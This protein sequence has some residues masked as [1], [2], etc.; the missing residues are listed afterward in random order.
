MKKAARLLLIV[1]LFFQGSLDVSAQEETKRDRIL[2]KFSLSPQVGL[3]H[4]WGDFNDEGLG[5]FFDQNDLGLSLLLNYKLNKFISISTGGLYG[6]LSGTRDNVNSTGAVNEPKD[7]GFGI[8]F[9]TDLFEFT[10]PRVELNVTRLIFKDKSKIFNKISIGV[11]GSHGIVYSNSKIYSQQ[12][13]GVNL[14]YGKHRGRSGNTVEAVT[15]YGLGLSYIINDRFDIGIESTI[16]NVWNDRL[17]AWET[18]GTAND[19]YSY[20]A[21]GVKYHLKKRNDVVKILGIDQPNTLAKGAKVEEEKEEV[22]EV[23]EEKKEEV[24]EVVEEKKDEV[25]P[26]IEEKKEEVAEVVEEKKKEVVS[27]KEGKTVSAGDKSDLTVYEGGGNFIAVAAFRGLQ[28]SKRMMNEVKGKGE[29]PIL[30]RNKKNTWY[31]ITIG[32]YDDK[33]I[34]LGKMREARA[35]GYERAWVHIK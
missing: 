20:T 25:V 33:E 6:K 24:A 27:L 17:D 29:N 13:E 8:L 14:V 31:I 19:K 26:V 1:G 23:V 10:L 3:L 30:I 18:P 7:L 15:S 9:K 2:R 5:G 34:A 32:K 11:I 21:I 35:K 22:A 16:R 4:S 28:G 12:D